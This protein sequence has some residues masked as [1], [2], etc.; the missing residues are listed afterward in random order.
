MKATNTQ[1]YHELIK[2]FRKAMSEIN[3]KS[4]PAYRDL[5]NYR[6]SANYQSAKEKIDTMRKE[7]V[8]EVRQEAAKEL[9]TVV[10]DM[11]Q[12]YEQ[13][14]SKAPTS[15]QLAILQALK[16]RD[17]V[18]R[19]ELREALNAVKGCPLCERVIGEIAAKNHH[20]LGMEQELT[21]DTIRRSLDALKLNGET[22]IAH[23]EYP[24][25]DRRT[26]VNG[27]NWG[28][29]R[30]DVDAKD[31]EDCMR[32]FGFVSDFPKFAEAVNGEGA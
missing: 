15:E 17:G 27:G 23:L 22:L 4:D 2:N 31:S 11:R 3:A 28:L 6:D 5:E 13:K 26:A 20:V 8:D 9:H 16:M 21:S 32:V 12:T 29:F 30:L 1:R 14:P 10:D 25:E 7:L 18:G 24:G 19:D